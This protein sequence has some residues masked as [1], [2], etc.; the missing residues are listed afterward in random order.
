MNLLA[1]HCH[2][3]YGMALVNIVQGNYILTLQKNHTPKLTY[4]VMGEKS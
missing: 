4:G 3:T 2:D 1:I